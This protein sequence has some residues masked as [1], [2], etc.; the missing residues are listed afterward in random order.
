MTDGNGDRLRS[1][2][3]RSGLAALPVGFRDADRHRRLILSLATSLLCH[4]GALAVAPTAPRPGMPIARPA[5][6]PLALTVRLDAR[7]PPRPAPT[8]ATI[9]AASENPRIAPAPAS[10]TRT[11]SDGANEPEARAPTAKTRRFAPPAGYWSDYRPAEQLDVRPLIASRVEVRYPDDLPDGSGRVAVIDV[12]INEEGRV[13]DVYVAQ[14]TGLPAADAEAVGAFRTAAYR[15]GEVAGKFV[16]SYVTIEVR[17]GAA[18]G[19][20]TLRQ[21]GAP[22]SLGKANTTS[23]ASP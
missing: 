4:V 1:P 11:A 12:F 13:V 17:F 20:A 23:S 18:T 2:L 19:V 15:P 21:L 9:E 3:L 8:L 22:N 14:S 16:R 10:A 7:L 5:A 6:A